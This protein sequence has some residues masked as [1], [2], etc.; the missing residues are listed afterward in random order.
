VGCACS[1]VWTGALFQALLDGDAEADESPVLGTH[2]LNP[3]HHS[4][5][6]RFKWGLSI[7]EVGLHIHAWFMFMASLTSLASKLNLCNTSVSPLFH[8]C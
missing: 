4:P 3:S 5:R 8:S 7:V 2:L 1:D 6:R